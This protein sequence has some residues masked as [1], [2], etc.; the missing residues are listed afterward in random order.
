MKEKG[1]FFDMT[2]MIIFIDNKLLY[3]SYDSWLDLEE[4]IRKKSTRM[5]FIFKLKFLAL[6]IVHLD[7]VI[8]SFTIEADEFIINY[9]VIFIDVKSDYSYLKTVYSSKPI[10]IT[11]AI[12]H[13]VH[14]E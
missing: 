3:L 14:I 8:N 1:Y 13:I 2:I 12:R 7:I 9:L 6:L 10:L 4:L 5:S 11:V